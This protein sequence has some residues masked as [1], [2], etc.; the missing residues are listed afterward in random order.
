MEIPSREDTDYF[1]SSRFVTE[2]KSKDFDPIATWRLKRHKCS[3]VLFYCAWCPHCK[4]VKKIWEH[5]GETAAFFDV[6]AYNCEK[7]W[8][9]LDQIKSDM[10]ELIRGFPTIIIYE[11]GEPIEKVGQTESERNVGHF[12]DACMRACKGPQV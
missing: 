5:L 6:C 3:I 1:A 10:P 11:N 2:L 4:A 12:I 8:T 9:H 7:N